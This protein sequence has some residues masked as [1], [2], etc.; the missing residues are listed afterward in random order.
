MLLQ[1]APRFPEIEI[2]RLA[3]ANRRFLV[4]LRRSRITVET[5]SV[6]VEAQD[7]CEAQRFADEILLYGIT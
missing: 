1:V 5:S 6:Y 2:F 7:E 4:E 3:T